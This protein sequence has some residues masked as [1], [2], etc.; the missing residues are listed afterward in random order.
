MAIQSLL[1]LSRVVDVVIEILGR[2]DEAE[3]GCCFHMLASVIR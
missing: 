2:V 3:G 1:G